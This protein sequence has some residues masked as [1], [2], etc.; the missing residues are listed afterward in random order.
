VAGREA[1]ETKMN[2]G[3]PGSALWGAFA[4]SMAPPEAGS[5]D[6]T[7]NQAGEL[8]VRGPVTGEDYVFAASGGAMDMNA[9]D[10]QA[11]M[12]SGLFRRA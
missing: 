9:R 12:R 11:L 3:N 8:R 6:L 1:K 7:Y 5:L 10:A 4:R 2:L